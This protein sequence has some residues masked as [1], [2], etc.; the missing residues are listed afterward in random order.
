[1]PDS[2]QGDRVALALDYVKCLYD[3]LHTLKDVRDRWFR[4]YLTLVATPLAV[5]WIYIKTR[6]E[7]PSSLFEKEMFL[8]LAAV[9]FAVGVISF[10]IYLRQRINVLSAYRRIRLLESHIVLPGLT[11]IAPSLAAEQ[12]KTLSPSQLNADAYA[13]LLH[14]IINSLWWLAFVSMLMARLSA[15]RRV[16]V[17]VDVAATLLCGAVHFLVRRKVLGAA[18][19]M[20]Y[21]P[22]EAVADGCPVKPS[23]SGVLGENANVGTGPP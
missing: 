18:E 19:R 5:L 9:F 7:G 20:I 11:E 13:S 2:S 14:I 12:A 1:M 23:D 15:G 21:G 22:A 3:D 4:H 16:S 6:P 10:L 8:A 17:C